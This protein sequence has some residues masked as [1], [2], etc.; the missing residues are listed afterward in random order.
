MPACPKPIHNRRVPKRKNRSQ[1]SDA[2]IQ[3]IFA[4]DHYQCVR[5]GDYRLES[6]PHH[7]IYRSA[8]GEGTKRNGISVCRACH[9][10]FHASKKKNNAWAVEWV[11]LNLDENG[12][13]LYEIEKLPK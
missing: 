2:T 3:A 4:R 1:F 10:F 5:C 6:V 13:L 9:D 11:R 7:V 12:D 8:G